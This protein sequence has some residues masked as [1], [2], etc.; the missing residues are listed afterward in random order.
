[1]LTLVVQICLSFDASLNLFVIAFLDGR[2]ESLVEC[3]LI[4]ACDL[5]LFFVVLLFLWEFWLLFLV[6][7]HYAKE[8]LYFCNF[9]ADMIQT[10]GNKN[11][12]GKWISRGKSF[13]VFSCS[14]TF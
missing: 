11:I 12:K 4:F 7:L 9:Y 14:L 6:M 5:L 3:C 10:R 8:L 13:V 1:M 2:D